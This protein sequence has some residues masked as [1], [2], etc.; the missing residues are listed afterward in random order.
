MNQ[1]DFT[2]LFY[3]QVKEQHDLLQELESLLGTGTH[4]VTIVP[5]GSDYNPKEC[6]KAGGVNRTIQQIWAH[7]GTEL[8]RLTFSPIRGSRKEHRVEGLFFVYTHRTLPRVFIIVTIEPVDFV[9]KALIPMLEQNR[10]RHLPHLYQ[11]Y[12]PSWLTAEFSR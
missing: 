4:T 1:I 10:A 2:N 12:R 8:Y 11:A 5:Y 6:F 9:R 7:D 3:G